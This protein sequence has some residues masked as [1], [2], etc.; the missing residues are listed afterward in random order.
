MGQ[1]NELKDFTRGQLDA[2]LMKIGQDAGMGTGDGIRAFLSG[3]LVV[4]RPV[5]VWKTWRTI[6]LGTGLKTA[7][8]FRK[9]ITE[10]GMKIGYW[11][12]DILGKP[13]FTVSPEEVEVD[14]IKVSVAELGFKDGTMYKNI[15]VRAR[16]L[17]LEHCPNEVGPQLRLQY[18]DQPKNER[19]RI[20][21]EAIVDSDACSRMFSVEPTDGLCLNGSYGEPNSFGGGDVQYLFLCRK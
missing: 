1:I 4:S 6:K 11:G 3:E 19:L 14:L 12:N 20:A 21:M 16:E 2:A 7:D 8:D 13:A 17:G 18:K 5:K 10:A 9:A 15:C